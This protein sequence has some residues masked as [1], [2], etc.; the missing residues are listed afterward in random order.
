MK[1]TAY[2][3]V[4]ASALSFV[5]CGGDATTEEH[6][7][8]TTETTEVTEEPVVEEE[9]AS[10]VGA[11]QMTAMDMGIPVPAGKEAEFEASMKE[12][13]EKTKYTFN[14]DGSFVINS[15][16]GEQKGTYTVE[17]NMLNSSM[18]G[19]EES[20]EIGELTADKLVLLIKAEGMNGSMTFKK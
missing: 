13:I 17:G 4:M 14:E 20:I 15:M 10:I 1:K 3:F 9:Q 18:D 11:W 5:A 6:A 19:K 7:E 2:I 12:A 16:I 8:E